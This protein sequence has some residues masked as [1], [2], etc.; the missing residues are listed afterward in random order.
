MY[1]IRTYHGENSPKMYHV[2]MYHFNERLMDQ[3]HIL[4]IP[5][6]NIWLCS[7]LLKS[8]T[9]K[10]SVK[11]IFVG[12]PLS[13]DQIPAKSWCEVFA[14]FSYPKDHKITI[15][16]IM[17]GGESWSNWKKPCDLRRCQVPGFLRGIVEP[18]SCND[19]AF[20]F[21]FDLTS[22]G[23]R[24]VDSQDLCI[25]KVGLISDI[26]YF[27]ILGIQRSILIVSH[28]ANHL[29]NETGSTLSYALIS[30]VSNSSFR[31]LHWMVN[32]Q[33]RFAR[34]VKQWG[35]HMSHPRDISQEWGVKFPWNYDYRII[36][37]L[38]H[39]VTIYL[40]NLSI[41]NDRRAFSKKTGLAYCE[42]EIWEDRWTM[43]YGRSGDAQILASDP[44]RFKQISWGEVP[45]F[46]H[47]I[48]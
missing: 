48:L 25:A 1:C 20:L 16:T 12:L 29:E 42:G 47:C 4:T 17:N 41:F 6:K 36:S 30:G 45:S 27:E 9:E 35:G 15:R 37:S 7:S 23:Q 18:R 24:R 33:N 39:G 2:D 19:G 14:F 26:T 10:R 43:K 28:I 5:E 22:L 13:R 11:H 38:L 34:L 8:A 40:P 21:G 44:S 46:L 32:G 31:V 3:Q